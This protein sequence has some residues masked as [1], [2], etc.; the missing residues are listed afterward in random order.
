[1]VKNIILDSW[2][3]LA[4]LEGES[5]GEKVK[6]LIHWVNGKRSLRIKNLIGDS[7]IER[8]RLFINIIN[9]GEVFCILGRRKGE[10]EANETISEIKESPI[11]VIPASNSLVFKAASLKVRYSI[12]YADAFAIATAITR[13]GFLLT[14]NPELKGLKDVPIIWIGG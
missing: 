8:I 9:L 2:S 11:E 5:Q 4:W 10:E 12:A 7:K 13:K 3:I 6:D 14:G 1:M